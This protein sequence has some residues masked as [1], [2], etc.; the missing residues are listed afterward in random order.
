MEDNRFRL[1]FTMLQN[2]MIL[3][4]VISFGDNTEIGF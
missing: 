3:D 4:K 1:Q 2:Y